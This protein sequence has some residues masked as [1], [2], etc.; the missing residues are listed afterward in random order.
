MKPKPALPRQSAGRPKDSAKREGIVRAANA[1]F[2]KNGYTLT[3]MESVAKKADVSKLTI[4][5]HFANKD[6]LFKEVIRQ[7]CDKL[8]SPESFMALANE[9][10]E[11]ALL[12]LG[13]N[14]TTHI[15]TQ[16]S[17]RLHSI[18]QAEAARHPKVVQIFFE[19]GP[20]RVRTA[21]GALLKQ[22]HDQKQLHIPDITKATEQFFSLLKGE[23]MM[24]IMLLQMP[25]PSDAA[26]KAHVRATVEFFLAAYQP[27]SQ[28]R[29]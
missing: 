14:F 22:W 10:V 1:L 21:F 5:S 17:L 27:K 7:R 2:M 8:G 24:R 26:R 23:M 25:L 3:S 16:D 12:Q 18:M 29:K 28:R 9:P 19:A 6:D 11:K 4:Y 15:F 13:I 20:K